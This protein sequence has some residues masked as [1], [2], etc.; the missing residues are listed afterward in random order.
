MEIDRAKTDFKLG[1]PIN[2]NRVDNLSKLIAIKNTIAT[3]TVSAESALSR[4]NRIYSK[5]R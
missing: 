3:S 4:M 2:P 5:L 1:I